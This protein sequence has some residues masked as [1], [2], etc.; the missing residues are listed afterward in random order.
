MEDPPTFVFPFT[1]AAGE[2]AGAA[3]DCFGG[4][5]EDG[6]A[7]GVDDAWAGADDGAT[8]AVVDAAEGAGRGLQ[9]LLVFDLLRLAR[10]S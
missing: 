5:L 7:A 2:G 8:K 4:E 9:R 6:A 1:F 10:A 3:D